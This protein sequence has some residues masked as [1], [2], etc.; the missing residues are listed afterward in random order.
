MTLWIPSVTTGHKPPPAP[1][2]VLTCGRNPQADEATW[3]IMFA[4]WQER[5]RFGLAC[6]QRLI[7]AA[8]DKADRMADEGWYAHTAPDGTTANEHVKRF[9]FPLAAGSGNEVE[10]ILRGGNGTAEQAIDALYASASHRPHL[11]GEGW[12]Q[13]QDKI[14]V[15]YANRRGTEWEHF[16]TVLI[17]RAG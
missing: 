14:G 8:Q 15:G 6:D 2:P 4:P 9:G 17:A 7:A 3:L 5:D 16:W 13:T 1:L 10:S 12:F 11:A